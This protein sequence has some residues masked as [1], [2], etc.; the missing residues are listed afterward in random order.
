MHATDPG[1]IDN[2][3]A[4]VDQAVP[5]QLGKAADHDRRAPAS[6]RRPLA[7]Q[8]VLRTD[9]NRAH[10]LA[11]L[12]DVARRRELRQ[13]HDVRAGVNSPPERRSRQLAVCFEVPDP[14][15]ELLADDSRHGGLGQLCNRSRAVRNCSIAKSRSAVL[16]AADIWVRMRA[17][18][19]GTTG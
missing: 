5:A 18:P 13:Q 8:R 12:E 3:G 15:S 7:E 14:R 1:V 11:R 9:R 10:L 4:V 2:R 19:C 6:L 16:C 17:V